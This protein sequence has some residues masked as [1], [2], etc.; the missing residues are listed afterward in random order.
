MFFEKLLSI[1]TKNKHIIITIL[2][3]KIKYRNK[4][5]K[6][7]NAVDMTNTVFKI[8]PQPELSYLTIGISEH[9]NLNCVSC[10]HFSPL[11]KEGFYDLK[12]FENDIKR[13]SQLSGAK[14]LKIALEGGEP[15][16]NKKIEEYVKITRNCFPRSIIVI[17]TNGLLLDKMSDDFFNCLRQNKTGLEITKYPINFNYDK[18]IEK[19]SNFGIDCNY[20]NIEL[21]KTSHKLPLDLEGKQDPVRNFINC[22]T[23]N[24]CVYLRAGKLFTCTIAPNIIHFNE[25][26]NKNLPLTKEDCIDIYKVSSMQEILSFL[27]KPIPFCKYCKIAE[28]VYGNKWKVSEKKIEEWV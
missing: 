5:S 3:I 23:G 7:N 17:I 6:N 19:I 26:F 11:A 1:K 16:L 9:C 20:K 10:D 21:V 13:L 28:M 24:Y 8:I 14:I 18:I 15:L 27:A 4:E 2:G 12:Q 25:F 22:T